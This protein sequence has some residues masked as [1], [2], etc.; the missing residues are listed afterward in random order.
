MD[1]WNDEWFDR[2]GLI[3]PLRVERSAPVREEEA[4][5]LERIC[6]AATPGPLLVDDAADGSGVVV[7]TLPDGRSIVSL[8]P[9]AAL[10]DE[11]AL[12]AN[13][14][15][16]CQARYMLL[17]LLRERDRWQT[18]REELLNRIAVLETVLEQQEPPKPRPR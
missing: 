3:D 16:I 14:Q 9:E 7:A 15:L 12:R 10:D 11:E 6:E 5:W 4:A 18:E 17:R 2:I 8:S 1:P 13:A